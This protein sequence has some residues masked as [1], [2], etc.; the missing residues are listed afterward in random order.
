L[1]AVGA[2]GFFSLM[3]YKFSSR[4]PYTFSMVVGIATVVLA[5]ELLYFERDLIEEEIEEF[6]PDA[7]MIITDR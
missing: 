5:V 1:R 3:M 7:E 2:L 4:E 6:E